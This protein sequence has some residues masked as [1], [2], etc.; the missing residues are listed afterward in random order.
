MKQLRAPEILIEK[1]K[2]DYKDDVACVVVMGSYIYNATHSRSD[3]DMYYIPKTK[4]GENLQQVFIIDGIGYDFWDIDW[5]R[6]ERIANHDERITSIITE[7]K[8]IYHGSKEDL[9]RFNSIKAKALDVSDRGKFINKAKNILN[10][11]YKNYFN[12]VNSTNITDARTYA[13]RIIFSLTYAIA[14]LNRDTVKRGRG[15]LKK[16]ILDMPFVPKDFSSLYDT[17]FENNDLTSIKNAYGQLISN[18]EELIQLEEEKQKNGLA[19]FKDNVSGYYEEMI[20]FYNKI[21]HACESG[22]ITTALFAAVEL[23]QEFEAAF[24]G[25]GVSIKELPDIIGAFDPSDTTEFLKKVAEHQTKLVELLRNKGVTIREYSN[26]DELQ[27]HM[28]TL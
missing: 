17:I 6:L 10:G 24:K 5:E 3:L 25:T 18:T 13:M 21:H 7:G 16:E 15:K 23:T 1:I 20:N 12:L 26:F 2:K 27:N 28:E 8:M 14:L 9:D 4:R 19:S 22:E 11:T